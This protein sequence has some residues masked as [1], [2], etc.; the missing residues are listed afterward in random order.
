MA[1]PAITNGEYHVIADS[2]IVEFRGVGGGRRNWFGRLGSGNRLRM[3]II[4]LR[5][6]I[7]PFRH[8]EALR[9]DV[10]FSVGSAS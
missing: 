10:F 8:R 4:N 5:D 2:M 9:I 1:S 6:E 3:D 7:S